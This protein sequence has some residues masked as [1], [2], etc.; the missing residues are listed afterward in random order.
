MSCIFLLVTYT[1]DSSDVA[2]PVLCGGHM[3]GVGGGS[4]DWRLDSVW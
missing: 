4:G 1:G 3:E 2:W